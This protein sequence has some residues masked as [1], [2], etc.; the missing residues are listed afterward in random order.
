MN[1]P[2]CMWISLKTSQNNIIMTTEKVGF[3]DT[4]TQT[5]DRLHKRT[6]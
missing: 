1:T 6:A 2:P 4:Q 3:I 5:G